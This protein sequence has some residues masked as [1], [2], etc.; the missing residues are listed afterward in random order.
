MNTSKVMYIVL[1]GMY[2]RV[3]LYKYKLCSTHGYL[4]TSINS[5]TPKGDLNKYKS[6]ISK[7]YVYKFVI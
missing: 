7:K 1:L 2:L 5:A 3:P 4:R 6:A